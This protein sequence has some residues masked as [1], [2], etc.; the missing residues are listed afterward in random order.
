[1]PT[2]QSNKLRLTKVYVP[3]V[4]QTEGSARLKPRLFCF[5]RLC[6]KG[7]LPPTLPSSQHLEGP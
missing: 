2:L 5:P 6:T 1:M 3:K 4:T 7:R